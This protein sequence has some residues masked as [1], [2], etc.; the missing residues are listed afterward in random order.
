MAETNEQASAVIPYITVDDPDAALDFYERA[1]GAVRG[2]VLK[3][4]D[5]I[6]HAE[7]RIGSSQ[8]MLSSE[9]PAL[10]L[11]S[12]KSLGGRSVRLTIYVP[13][14]DAAYARAVAAGATAEMPPADQF[15]GDRAAKVG[16]P[17]GHG[18]SF[19]TR[20]RDVTEAEMQ[21]ALDAWSARQAD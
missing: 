3:S 13:D 17:F 15:Y 14:C 1:F 18:W 16:D 7:M 9:W 10:N 19:H 11:R 2:L 4:G 6:G 8:I 5:R 21:A 12:P 20:I